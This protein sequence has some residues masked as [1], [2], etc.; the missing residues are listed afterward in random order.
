[1]YDVLIVGG[2]LA[3]LS[4]AVPLAKQGANVLILEAR[5]RMGGRV[6]SGFDGSAG[7]RIPFELGGELVASFHTRLVGHCEELGI[8]LK[9]LQ[10]LSS[11][12]LVP[13][14]VLLGGRFLGPVERGRLR[15]ELASLVERLAS[16]ARKVDPLV[17]WCSGFS[18]LDLV[19]VD[20]WLVEQGYS[21]TMQA[22]FSDLAPGSQSML[23][24]LAM[25]S[26]GGGERFFAELEMFSLNGSG[27]TLI[28]RLCER[29]TELS[30]CIVMSAP[31]LR[32]EVA[33][34]GVNAIVAADGY[35]RFRARA[36]IV[37]TPPATWNFVTGCRV[38]LNGIH[39]SQN[40][41]VIAFLEATLISDDNACCVTD[42]PCRV[43]QCA[44]CEKLT[45]ME[46][47]T[48]P[49]LSNSQ[50]ST[51]EVVALAAG[52]CGM[53]R[54][55]VLASYEERWDEVIWSQG[56]YASIGPHRLTSGVLYRLQEGGPITF[57]GDCI[58]P[59]FAGFMEGAVRSGE[60]AAS[61]VLAYL[62]GNSS[63]KRQRGRSLEGS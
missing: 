56:S 17:P 2:G 45:R 36:A 19:S 53:R 61:T 62:G 6:F 50:L 60:L 52:V 9:P 21:T 33:G 13:E 51:S 3:G 29:F 32:L 23:A 4:A 30:G 31:V 22:F 41:K 55:K 38:P 43:I 46:I 26:A 27:S 28:G 1:M 24:L 39:L 14:R 16:L 34:P 8:S 48:C 44:N 20:E 40:R 11:D 54:S 7:L 63:G 15:A 12:S 57:A 47:L 5:A 37:A 18:E 42:L 58:L 35:A 25:V 59:G 49:H 10:R